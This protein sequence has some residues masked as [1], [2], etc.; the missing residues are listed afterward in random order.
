MRKPFVSLIANE[1][2]QVGCTGQTVYVLGP[3]GNELAKFRDLTHAYYP[4]LHPNGE[5]AA[6]YSNDG[7]IAIYS[8]TLKRTNDAGETVTGLDGLKV[9]MVPDFEKVTVS[10]FFTTLMD[11]LG[12]LFYSIS[13]AMGIMIA[14]GSYVPD[15]TN[16][17]KSVNQ[18]EI[19]DTLVAFLAG[20]MIIP[21]V[22]VFQGVDG[23]K[24][25]PSLMFVALP[26]VFQEMG[27][28]GKVI[29]TL[30]FAMVL[31][32]ALTSAVSILEAVVSSVIDKIRMRRSYAVLAETG[33][34]LLIAVFVCLGYNVLYFEAQLPNTAE[35]GNAQLLDILDYISNNILMPVVAIATCILIGWV[36]KP[37]TVIDEVTKN[38]EKLGRRRLYIVMVKFVTPALL[39]LLLLMALNVIKF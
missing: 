14:Y 32:A 30:F 25:G 36:L 4:A 34:A 11:A 16:M 24:S 31:F 10:S 38:G 29:G 20:V 3:A 27:S 8:L 5:V 35:G 1:R 2:Y 19:F 37:K 23:M 7:V 22:Y 15:E 26:K 28:F 13:V 17:V 18:I 9:Y 21:A 39:L 12:Q 33:L 6:V